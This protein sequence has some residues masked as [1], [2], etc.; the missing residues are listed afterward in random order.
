MSLIFC[1]SFDHYVTADIAEKW[2]SSSGGTPSTMTISAGTGGRASA[3]LR[4]SINTGAD[5]PAL[6]LIPTIPTPS[7]ATCV[8][9]FRFKASALTLDTST[10]EGTGT[11][12][13]LSIRSAGATHV[14]FR[15]NP[16]GTMS[17]LRGTTVLATSTTAIA[18][19]V[20]Y[21][22]EFRVV[23]SDTV[24]V[25]QYRVDGLL[26]ATLDISSQDTNSG[27][28]NTW[29]GLK[30]GQWS[31]ASGTPVLDYDDL[32][33]LDGVDS[34]I[35][36]APNNDFLGDVRIDPLYGTADGNHQDST[37]STGTDQYAMVDETA[38]NDDTD[39]NTL[40]AA[41]KDTFVMQNA[42]VSGASIFGV[43]INMHAKKADAGIATMRALARVAGTTYNA[44]TVNP[45]DGYLYKRGIFNGNPADGAAW[46]TADIDA[47]E[48]GYERVT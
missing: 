36:G 32:Y 24:G 41:G 28:A 12:V 27:G 34:T 14:W 3:S 23:I 33:L 47:A 17:V 7:G 30:I 20:F 6:F 48:F 44:S 1:D 10:T 2:N 18:T 4:F 45:A 29:D 43:Q 37:P 25:V 38:P 26:D 31:C 35:T 19:G 8:V 21:Y 16:A 46:E 22:M 15:L 13:I 39:Y 9:G 40:T 42:P 5:S 11:A